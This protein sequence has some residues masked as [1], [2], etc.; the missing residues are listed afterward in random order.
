MGGHHS[1]VCLRHASLGAAAG[2]HVLGEWDCEGVAVVL[3]Q[4]CVRLRCAEL[5]G[6]QRVGGGRPGGAELQVGLGHP[7]GGSWGG[8]W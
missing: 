1:T 4:P 6:A 8:N 5:R 2:C 3:T 7:P